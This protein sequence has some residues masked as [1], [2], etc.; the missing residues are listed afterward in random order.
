MSVSH[1]IF[2][3]EQFNRLFP[4]YLLISK[5][6]KIDI[7]GTAY[8]NLINLS[9]KNNFA[10]LFNVAGKTGIDHRHLDE[11]VGKH[12][13]ISPVDNSNI[14]LQGQLEY[15]AQTDHYLFAGNAIIN[16]AQVDELPGSN[17]GSLKGKLNFYED[18]LN[19]V[20]VDIVVFD[21]EHRYLFINKT[22]IKDAALRKRMI[23]LKD[24]DFCWLTNRPESVAQERR[25]YFNEVIQTRRI[26][27]WE[28]KLV[29]ADGAVHYSLRNMYPVLDDNKEVKLVIG[30]GLDIT[31]RKI[32][33][34]Q[35]LV[36]EKKY[37]DLYNFSPALIYTHDMDGRVMSINPAITSTLGYVERDVVNN[38][39]KSILPVYDQDKVQREY[40]EKL[41]ANGAARGIF[42]A[43]HKNRKDIIYLF[44][45]SYVA[46]GEDGAEPYI[47][48]FS[49]DITDRIN[50]EKE[51]RAAKI[52]TESAARAKEIFL[53]NMSH[54]IRTPM[55]G[56]L[57]LNNLL[58]KTELNE[59]QKGYT[60]LIAESVNN[61]L[62]IIN[63]ILDIEKIG[64]GKLELESRPFNISTKINRTMQLFQYKSKE[65][66]LELILNNRLPDEFTVIGDQFRFAQI[67][68]NLINNSI[69]F[70][71]K[72]SITISAALL[73]NANNKVLLEFSVRDTGIGISEERLPV[74]FD[75]F[76]QGSSSITRK[77][78]GT[79]LGLSICKSLV[80]MQGGHIKVNSRL[81]E[82][83]EFIFSLTY[84]K[85]QTFASRDDDDSVISDPDRL[86]G[87]K[88]LVAEDVE[89]NQFLVRNMLESWGCEVDIVPNGL[90]AVEKIKEETYDLVLMDIQMPEMDGITA[91]RQIRQLPGQKGAE[92]PIIALTANAL[93]GDSQ[94]YI[95]AGMNDCVTKPY[96]EEFL[97]ERIV[98]NLK[99]TGMAPAGNFGSIVAKEPE[100]NI[101]LMENTGKLYDLTMIETI[102]KNNQ[103]FV[104]KMISMFCDITVQDVDKLK[105]AATSGDWETV[106]QLAHKLKSTVGN[107]GVEPLKDVLRNL[108][109]RNHDNPNAL[110]AELDETLKKVIVQLKADHPSAFSAAPIN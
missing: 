42:R 66:D 93:K 67:L 97:Y 94:Y 28:E 37:R 95:D 3:T 6:L 46:G 5:E 41:K 72:G 80:E 1:F 75:P 100:I 19:E 18:V 29:N 52:T 86:M 70:T 40:L 17:T 101:E 7:C 8:S 92:I 108:E 9:G 73:Y 25:A 103:D 63:D 20:P 47:I 54:E 51:L 53:A 36:N 11:F 56:I 27:S 64:S 39:L 35:L 99:L 45:Q 106:G 61:L 13:T 22:A 89:L 44:Y 31:G 104:N 109:L 83:T 102:S 96:T 23:G 32:V 49:H 82:G 4:Y 10:A 43:L 55:N 30:Y 34:E 76:V 84:K 77:Y 2:N 14:Q 105:A 16:S 88:I 38:N 24:E 12:L 98:S 50:I 60:K 69:K 26:K 74:I 21:T 79:G 90:N 91:T 58:A 62:T 15:L 48:G 59:Q 81:N 85:G 65:K 33:D 68:S 107:M 78:G 110:V 57:G 71:K 87:K